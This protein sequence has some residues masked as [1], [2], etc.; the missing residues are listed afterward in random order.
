MAYGAPKTDH[1][2]FRI[3]DMGFRITC[4][5]IIEVKG[6]NEIFKGERDITKL[7]L[8]KKHKYN[9]N[10]IPLFTPVKEDDVHRT[11]KTAGLA[12]ELRNVP[13]SPI[14]ELSRTLKKMGNQTMVT[15][16]I[17][18]GFSNHP[19]LQGLFFLI[20]LI[21]YLVTLVGNLLILTAIRINPVLHTPMYYFLS[22][23]SF[24]DICYTS[25]TVPIMLVNFF[26]EKKTISYE[27]CL[28]QLFFLVTFAG[29]ESVLLAAMAY[30]RFIAICYPLRY[31]VLMSNKVCAYLAAGSWLCGLVDSLAH[32]GLIAAL[33]LCG[34][35]QINHF[36]CDIPLLLKLSCSDTS[37]NEVA[38]YV[39]SATIG[40]SPCLFTA[41]S[42][43]L[44]IS[45]ILKIQSAQGRQKAFSTCASHLTVVVIYYGTIN[46]NYDRPSAGFSLDVDILASVL[47]CIVTP[48]LNPIIYSLRN[49]EVKVALRKLCEGYILPCDSR[50]QINS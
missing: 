11:S 42:Y 31:P 18:L 35:N 25:T 23:L 48:M 16:F 19:V 49:K 17:F 26:R 22:N 15:E 28:S 32:T 9:T 27:G 21:V 3:P 5:D 29:S 38:L 4:I 1:W 12:Q 20:F 50:V 43:M 33:T 30:D 45:A 8:P 47:F 6:Q 13:A 34:P 36:F 7:H 24:L 10:G 40:M 46:F 39:A 37:V 44:I 14:M 41:V 2:R